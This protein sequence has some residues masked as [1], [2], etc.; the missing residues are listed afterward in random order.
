MI[1]IGID[2]HKGSHTA[3]AVEAS[4][5]RMLGV[6]TVQARDHGHDELVRWARQWNQPHVFAIEDCRHVS[7][8]LER[9]LLGRGERVVRVAPK[10]IGPGP[11]R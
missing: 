8:G 9:F 10:L 3:A 1:V 5:G 6:R 4:T 2:P 11:R 7:G